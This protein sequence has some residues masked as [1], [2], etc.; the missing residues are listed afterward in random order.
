LNQT[1]PTIAYTVYPCF[2][3]DRSCERHPPGEDYDWRSHFRSIVALAREVAAD[4]RGVAGVY[5]LGAGE[6]ERWF[7]RSLA[8]VDSATLE[9]F[10]LEI[11]DNYG[12]W[13]HPLQWLDPYYNPHPSRV[14][15]ARARA[16]RR[17]D[18]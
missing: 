3:W 11:T 17:V 7:I 14:A 9:V 4:P 16:H 2:I 15:S 5:W 1:P 6:S 12:G 18:E 10:M 8:N 13:S